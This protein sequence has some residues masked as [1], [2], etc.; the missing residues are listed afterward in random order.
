MQ[1]HCV[2]VMRVKRQ[3]SKSF[4]ADRTVDHFEKSAVGGALAS[5]RVRRCTMN[6]LAFNELAICRR[7][8]GM[9]A[10][11]VLNRFGLLLIV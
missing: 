8:A 11:P 7:H 6:V 5:G 3:Q 2:R 1:P 4:G 9:T 10:E